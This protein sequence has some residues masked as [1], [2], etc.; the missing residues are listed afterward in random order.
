MGEELENFSADCKKY[1]QEKERLKLWE[2][3]RND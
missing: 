1:F 2:L 3:E